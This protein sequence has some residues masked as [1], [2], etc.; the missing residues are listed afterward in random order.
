[1]N[2]YTVMALADIVVDV[3]ADDP[4][5]AVKEWRSRR[6]ARPAFR[7]PG[8][9][10]VITRGGMPRVIDKAGRDVTPPFV[11]RKRRRPRQEPDK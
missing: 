3:Q 2:R 5:A 7:L 1:M 6:R 10:E 11:R 9:A 4:T 8:G